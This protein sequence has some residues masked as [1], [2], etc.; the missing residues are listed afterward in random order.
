M[1]G[2]GADSIEVQAQASETVVSDGS[3]SPTSA[4]PGTGAS[5]DVSGIAVDPICWYEYVGS[6]E[7]VAKNME[8]RKEQI[9]KDKKSNSGVSIGRALIYAFDS[10]A[11]WEDRRDQDGGWYKVNCDPSRAASEEE[12]RQTLLGMRES[13]I[14]PNV[15]LPAGTPMPQPYIAGETLARAVMASA[16]IPTP[17]IETNPAIGNQGS[18]LVGYDTWVWATDATVRST[19]IS[20]TAGSTTATVTIAATGLKL[21][22]PDS[23]VKCTGF[24]QPWTPQ[25]PD[26]DTTDCLIVFTRSSAHLGG[27]TPLTTTINYHTTFTATD[28][29]SGSLG[30]TSTQSE[31]P[32]PVAEVQTLNTTDDD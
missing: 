30:I 11:D 21:S 25:T 10:Y 32:I 9:E 31:T 2:G 27:T 22:A 19:T 28:G 24:G 23:Q 8:E 12:Y 14:S 26:W 17:T 18:T 29:T 15:W 16:T 13:A 20:A 7:E 4:A 5:V 6:G 3:G 1:S